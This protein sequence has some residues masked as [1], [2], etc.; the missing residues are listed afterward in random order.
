MNFPQKR[1]K[2]FILIIVIF[3]IIPI[4]SNL[5]AQLNKEQKDLIQQYTQQIKENK[6]ANNLQLASYYSNKCASIY[7]AAGN[8]KDAIDSYLLSAEMNQQTGND[9]DIKK[10]YN[11][12]AMIYSEMGQLNNSQKYFEKSLL[13]SRRSNNKS[14]IAISLMDVSTILIFSKQYIDAIK[15]LEEALKISYD[16]DDYKNLRTCYSL[17]AQ[18]YKAS[19]D[20]KKSD[21]YY[22][23]FLAYDKKLNENKNNGTVN[24]KREDLPKYP[25][26]MLNVD[27][28]KNEKDLQ[29]KN[30][31]LLR[32]SSNIDQKNSK[33][34][35]SKL[36][37]ESLNIDK[38]L[39]ESKLRKA[40]TKNKRYKRLI[41]T[42]IGVLTILLII[43][44][45]G[46]FHIRKKQK[47]I[48]QLE[49]NLSGSEKEKT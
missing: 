1:S 41:Y 42:G 19:G 22:K 29:S 12:I 38:I 39:Y 47:Y 32:D 44:G 20:M 24:I 9:L 28:N 40:E 33:E 25:N 31:N 34:N 4:N 18:C 14:E 45:L 15:N 3:T 48:T 5:L 2:L 36:Q 49:Q 13:I 30:L 46:I 6:S 43:I 8:Y 23:Y 27:S 37:T 7:L 11:N 10:I 35:A 16:I 26:N 17:L 21:E